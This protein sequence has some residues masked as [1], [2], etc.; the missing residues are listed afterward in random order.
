MKPKI[1]L[2]LLIGIFLMSFNLSANTQN[3]EDLRDQIAVTYLSQVGVTEATG[4][5]DGVMVET[6]QA[7]ADLQKGDPWCA[8]FV[9]WC[10]EV[11]GIEGPRSFAGYSPAWFPSGRHI[12]DPPER[13]DI[14]GI[15][16]STKGRIAHVGFIDRWGDTYVI[17]VEGNTNG[18]GSRDGGAVLKKRRL[19]RQIY[20]TCDWLNYRNQG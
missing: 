20:T 17:T 10:F 15:Y 2:F 18:V 1:T 4:A 11:N 3:R 8:A 5:N 6:Y 14:F 19:A 9:N 7:S 12:N 16:Y 13:A